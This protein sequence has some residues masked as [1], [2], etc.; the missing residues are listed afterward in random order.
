MINKQ[1]QLKAIAG[2]IHVDDDLLEE[3]NAELRL[4]MTPDTPYPIKVPEGKGQVLLAKVNDLPAYCPPAGVASASGYII[5]K[6]RKGET[7][8]SISRKYRTSPEVIMD[9]NGFKRNEKLAA[10]WRIKVPANTRSV[11]AKRNQRACSGRCKKG[12]TRE[13]RG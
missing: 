2:A 12:K 1:V 7:I 8:A 6:V 13:V 5:H 4:D 11:Q 10:G 3:L 9:V